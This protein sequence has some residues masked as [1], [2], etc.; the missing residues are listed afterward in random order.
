M[1]DSSTSKGAAPRAHY[2]GWRTELLATLA[3]SRLPGVTVT[4]QPMAGKFD[5]SVMTRTGFS[6][7]LDVKGLSS[8]GKKIQNIETVSELRWR[9]ST[10]LLKRATAM[11][12]PVVLF[13]LDADTGHGRYLRLD[14]LKPVAPAS[15]YQTIRLPLGNTINTASLHRMVKEL[16]SN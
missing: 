11:R 2:I 14:T 9:I 10:A 4:K 8:M 6:F 5:F 16:E 13:L 7:L 12:C 1:S 3:L 15:E